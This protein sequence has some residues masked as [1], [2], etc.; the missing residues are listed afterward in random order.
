MSS[1]HVHAGDAIPEVAATHSEIGQRS[2]QILSARRGEGLDQGLQAA[3]EGEH[4]ATRPCLNLTF[5][6][7]SI[8]RRFG[9][10]LALFGQLHGPA[11]EAAMMLFEIPQPAE[12]GAY[13]QVFGTAGEG[14][15]HERI[16]GVLQELAA[17]TTQNEL[18]E[19]F[20]GIGRCGGDE[21]LAGEAQLC[22][23][24]EQS[25]L[26]QRRRAHG[27][28]LQSSIAH[29]VAFLGRVG[30]DGDPIVESELADQSL[31]GR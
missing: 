23:P 2:A 3:L 7:R 24:R 27:Q 10:S 31:H 16:D 13:A 9:G 22:A 5:V 12:G 29:D 18:L 30:G 19:R 4:L 26:D 1:I 21:G 14:A 25:A 6:A 8:A 20:F 28:R 17:Q 11:D 15:G